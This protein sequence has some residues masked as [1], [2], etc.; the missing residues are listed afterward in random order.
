MVFSFLSPTTMKRPIRTIAVLLAVACLPTSTAFA[1]AYNVRTSRQTP[2][3]VAAGSFGI[4]QHHLEAE[5]ERYASAPTRVGLFKKG[6]PAV[7]EPEQS[8]ELEISVNPF[9]GAAWLALIG[10]AFLVAPGTLN[11]PDDAKMLET[12]ITDPLNGGDYNRLWFVIWNYFTVV[13]AILASLMIPNVK[14]NQWLSATPF[15]LGSAFF[16]YFALGPYMSL[17]DSTKVSPENNNGKEFGFVTKNILDTRVFGA[18]LAALALEIPFT[19][20][21]ADAFAADPSAVVS[22]FW[23]LATSSRFVSVAFTDITIMIL[24][25]S[26]LIFEDLKNRRGGVE[27]A[28]DKLVAAS[29]LLA[30]GLGAAVYLACRP[31]KAGE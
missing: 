8:E 28:S 24:L 6:A 30:P 29:T 2:A 4:S 12:F 21:F 5:I 25:S 15:V 17:R 23:D 7:T 31:K 14:P 13:P 27:E 1:P 11:G 16:G 18:V 26:I 22:G 9:Y 10:F 3:P 20:G 19:T